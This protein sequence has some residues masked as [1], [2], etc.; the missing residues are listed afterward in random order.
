MEFHRLM[1]SARL[2]SAI[3]E[4]GLGGSSGVCD[5]H[6]GHR[7]IPNH[8]WPDSNQWPHNKHR[9]LVGAVVM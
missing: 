9:F 2:Q 8:S 7:P 1:V 5:H 4:L 6:D 3:P